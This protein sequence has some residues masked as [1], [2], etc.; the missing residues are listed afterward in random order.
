MTRCMI[1]VVVTTVLSSSAL[2]AGQKPPAPP[3]P[4]ADP[5]SVGPDAPPP[6][7]A[8]GGRAR[9]IGPNV[10]VEVTFSEQRAEG[11]IPPKTVTVTTNDG[12]WGR[13]R[14]T[15]VSGLVNSPLNVD[16]RPEMQ[17]DGRVLLSLNLEYGESRV[18]EGQTP[19]FGQAVAST[20]NES[21]T[22][23]LETGEALTVT[24]SAD[25][26]SDRKVTVDVKATVLR[27]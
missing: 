22:V 27:N 15:V 8:P 17:P 26:M 25:P 13:V 14:S 7:P 16:A 12:H 24:Q 10:R 5:V 20:L 2:G 11:V 19:K 4:P 1:A 18:P 3:P 6:P 9:K 21:V 23:L